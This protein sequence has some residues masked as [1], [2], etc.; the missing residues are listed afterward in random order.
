MVGS[1]IFQNGIHQFDDK[2]ACNIVRCV[3]ANSHSA[4]IGYFA[5][6]CFEDVKCHNVR[7]G[8]I[9]IGYYFFYW[10]FLEGSKIF[11]VSQFMNSY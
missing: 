11:R 10:K 6:N 8:F 5:L 7:R 4:V 3:I 9:F 2:T 1:L